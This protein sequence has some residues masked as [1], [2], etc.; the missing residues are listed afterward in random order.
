[1][2]GLELGEA[3]FTALVCELGE[4]NANVLGL[5]LGGTKGARPGRVCDGL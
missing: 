3:K 5:Y 4:V 2:L 1:M